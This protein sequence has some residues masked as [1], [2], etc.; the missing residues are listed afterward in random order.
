MDTLGRGMYR[1]RLFVNKEKVASE[2]KLVSMG[3]YI[4]IPRIRPQELI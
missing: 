4:Q 1:N 2:K 3:P